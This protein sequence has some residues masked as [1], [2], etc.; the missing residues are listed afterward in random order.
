MPKNFELEDRG[1]SLRPANPNAGA[2]NQGGRIDAPVAKRPVPPPPTSRSR[3]DSILRP[4]SSTKGSIAD[5]RGDEVPQRPP[6]SS[7]E[8][9]SGGNPPS[10][11]IQPGPSRQS[12]VPPS[13]DRPA[14]PLPALPS[15]QPA[16]TGGGPGALTAGAN[17]AGQP[18][19]PVPG[20]DG[21]K[22][23]SAPPSPANT[24][25]ADPGQLG[26]G[27]PSTPNQEVAGNTIDQG[28]G[29]P[30]GAPPPAQP[31]QSDPQVANQALAPDEMAQSMN[32]RPAM[33]EGLLGWD[34]KTSQ[35]AIANGFQGEIGPGR[36]SNNAGALGIPGQAN[37]PEDIAFNRNRY[38]QAL[39][40]NKGD[41]LSASISSGSFPSGNPIAHGTLK[42]MSSISDSAEG[43]GVDP[44]VLDENTR[45]RYKQDLARQ[46][47][48]FGAYP[49]MDDP[50]APAPPIRPLSYS[51]NPFT[52]K[53]VNPEGSESVIDRFGGK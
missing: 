24:R 23:V 47:E 48:E 28:T 46:T 14:P 41:S 34:M 42:H 13:Q 40:Q 2:R 35:R 32:Q 29:Q 18:G 11:G 9:R 20:Q 17:P 30:Q 10:V 26:Q 21:L 6:L 5:G 33:G 4:I 8:D 52:G 1:Q 38:D 39:K 19:E 51:F 53:W 45:R 49:G 25:L 22:P 7:E 27:P 36:P 50:D 12:G 16:V 3:K 37:T 15:E 43:D 31:P 44:G